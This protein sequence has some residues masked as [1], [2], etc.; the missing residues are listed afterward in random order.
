MSVITEQNKQFI[1]FV[2]TL[3]ILILFNWHTSDHFLLT[4]QTPCQTGGRGAGNHTPPLL[5]YLARFLSWKFAFM[6]FLKASKTYLAPEL[7]ESRRGPCI[8]YL[9]FLINTDR[10]LFPEEDIRNGLRMIWFEAETRGIP[11]EEG[12]RLIKSEQFFLTIVRN[13]SHQS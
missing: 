5:P 8:S 10:C 4:M 11:V 13:T 1:L 3:R 2:V 12:F 7:L 6:S 9:D